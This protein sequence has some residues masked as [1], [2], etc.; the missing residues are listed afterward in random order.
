MALLLSSLLIYTIQTGFFDIVSKSFQ[1]AFTRDHEKRKFK[2]IPP[3]SEIVAIDQKPLLI[4]GLLLGVSMG[5]GLAIYYI[6][7]A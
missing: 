2:D 1:Y 3:L 7:P 6:Y 4:Y 5:I